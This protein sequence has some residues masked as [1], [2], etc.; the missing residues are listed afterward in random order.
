MI[1]EAALPILYAPWLRA[2]T[3]G[4]IPAETQ[5]TCDH[6][7]MLPTPDSPPDATY[8]YPATKCCSCQPNIPNFLA[9]KILSDP[10]P[11]TAEGRRALEQRIATR[12]AVT[13]SRVGAGG[14]FELLYANIP[15]GRAPALR[16]RFLTPQATCGVWKY[17]PGVCATWF[18]K[19]VR[20]ATGLRFWKLAGQLLREVEQNLALWCLAELKAGWGELSELMP[21]TRPDVAELEGAIDWARYRKLWGEWAGRE[22]DFYRACASLV[23]S[24]RWEQVEQ[25]CGPRVRIL[26]ELARDAYAHLESEAIPDRLRLG[27]FRFTGFQGG[28]YRVTAYHPYDPL[29]M[30]APL[31]RVLHYFDGRPTQEALLA[32]LTEQGVRLSPSL[33]RRLVDFGILTTCE[34]EKGLLPV[35][36]G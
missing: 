32:I 23:D 36:N 18:C 11:S 26:A 24:L 25:A 13:P 29:L 30:A 34:Q 35:L 16:C 17:R 9:G 1:P 22:T 20:G 8:F 5:A 12:V 6:C 4:P 15:F 2:I 21:Q 7:V 28:N 31:A 19:H 27:E 3:G 33:V 14:A 10:D